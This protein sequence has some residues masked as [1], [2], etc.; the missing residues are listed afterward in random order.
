MEI[1]G[2]MNVTPSLHYPLSIRLELSG[3]T[4]VLQRDA[5]A[6]A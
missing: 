3:V 4:A 2:V 6:S 5:E 1:E